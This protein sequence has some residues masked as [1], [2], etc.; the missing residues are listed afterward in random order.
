[1]HRGQRRAGCDLQ[2][3]SGQGREHRGLGARQIQ[4]DLRFPVD[5]PAQRRQLGAEAGRVGAQRAG[6][7]GG[8]GG[9]RSMIEPPSAITVWPVMYC[10]S[11]EARNTTIG[12]MSVRGS[13]NLP[14]GTF[15]SVLAA[16][17]GKE[18]IQFCTPSVAASGETML[19]R[20]PSAAHS[21]AATRLSPRI[22]SL[23]AA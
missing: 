5:R 9:H 8:H 7:E 2:T 12:A 3:E 10:D 13:P 17:S 21:W 22:A 23:A 14:S 20:M 18:S 15:F 11:S 6:V 4:A 1:G 19:T 16:A